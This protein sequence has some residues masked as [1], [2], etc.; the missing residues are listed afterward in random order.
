MD[1][2]PENGGKFEAMLMEG[3]KKRQDT[4]LK[5]AISGW[6]EVEWFLEQ[7]CGRLFQTTAVMQDWPVKSGENRWKEREGEEGRGATFHVSTR[8]TEPCELVI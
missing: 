2:N 6:I 1:T 8:A 4:N 3:R 5:G 7:F